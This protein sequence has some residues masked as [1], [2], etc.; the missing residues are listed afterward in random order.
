MS[1]RISTFAAPLQ[2][3][4]VLQGMNARLNTMTAEVSSGLNSN[5]AGAMG[6]NAS[7][8]Y[9]LQNQADQE[10]VVQTTA[11]TAGNRLD[12]IQTALTSVASSVQTIATGTINSASQTPEGAAALGTEASN[13]MSQVLNLLNTQ[14]NGSALFAGDATSNPPMRSADAAGGPQDAINTV[15]NTAVAANGGQPLTAANVDNLLNGPNGLASIFNNTNSN[16]AL[17]YNSSFYTAPDDGKPTQV[18]IGVNQTVQYNA[19]ANQPAFK[20]LMQGLSM[21]SMLSAPSTQLD[22]TAQSAILTQATTMIGQAQNELTT[23]QGQLGAV[24]AQLQQV[25][26]AQQSAANA[27]TAQVTSL[28]AAD[29]YATATNLSA[30]Q[31]QLAASYQVTEALSQ[32]TLSHYLPALTG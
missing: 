6:N 1:G 22:S 5:P 13:T 4:Y 17:N 2:Q 11:T 23:Q 8:L 3:E 16:P 15:L 12:A 28:E 20:D 26:N 19:K 30:L 9:S 25:S 14:Y 29:P 24:Q 31:N 10:N 21:L 27:T 7:L 18:L 32:L